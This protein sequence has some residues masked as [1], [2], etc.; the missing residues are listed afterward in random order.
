MEAEIV[1]RAQELEKANERL[2][3]SEERMR[4]LVESVTDYAIFTVTPNGLIDT[5]NAGAERIFG[6]AEKE[7]V[8]QAAA[9]LF[10]PQDRV[11]GVP[12]QEL[13]TAAEKGRASD[14]RWHIRKDGTSLYMS[15]VVS[16]IGDGQPRGFVK[17][18]RDL[19][20]QKLMEDELRLSHDGLESRVHERTGELERLNET[21]R[22]EIGERRAMEERARELVRQ[23]VTVQEDE[24]LRIARDLHDQM[25]QQL[26]ALRLKLAAHRESCKDDVEMCREVDEIES[27]AGQLDSEVDFLAW[28]L[29]LAALDDLGLP[30]TLANFVQEWSQHFGIPA[31]FH[32]AGLDAT[33]FAPNIEINLYRIAQEALNN[34]SKHA[35][36]SRADVILERRDQQVV[37]IIEDNGRGFD[38]NMEKTPTDKKIGLINM[39]ER[40]ALIGGT[41]EIETQPGEGTTIFARVPIRPED[42]RAEGESPA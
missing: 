24:R 29:R 26:T 27:L 1:L 34:V 25:G 41:L 3:A 35:Q 38:P 23:L 18:A 8:G 13:K 15:G 2:R 5:W 10:T 33:R 42:A 16:P 4:L 32:I 22:M 30:V 17:I 7:I 20:T 9:V 31:E 39:S 21:L 12:E 37:L 6:Y 28:E 36:C 40:A 14:E 11:R 19:T